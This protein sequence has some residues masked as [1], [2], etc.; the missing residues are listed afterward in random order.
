[1]LLKNKLKF[2][3]AIYFLFV[4]FIL[5]VI[6]WINI[7]LTKQKDSPA[8]FQF[9]FLYGLI[10]FFGGLFGLF[11][12]FKWGF[13][14]SAL[15][16]AL[17]FLSCGLI[18]WSGGETIWS[19]YNLVLNVEIPYPSWADASFIASWPLWIAG[20]YFL[21]HATGAKFGLKRVAGR[22]QLVLIPIVAILISYY[23]LILVARDGSWTS[24]EGLLK[25]FFDFAY[26]ILDIVILT[27]ALLVYGLSLKF[28][29]GRFKWPVLIILLGFVINYFA[30]FGFSY[31]TTVET[32]F[33][34]S[35]PDLLFATTMFVLSVGVN[36]LDP[37]R[38]DKN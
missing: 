21:S 29:G 26:P 27:E 22:L 18:T 33:N 11:R 37:N 7:F 2:T 23:L 35:W 10:P 13:L 25:V 16:K 3:K 36:S 8:N 24:G 4:Y 17:F 19:Y 28:L 12:A 6:W 1:M 38:I 32:Y 30:D 31:T 5:I 9:V 14:K 15:G 34:A 20:V